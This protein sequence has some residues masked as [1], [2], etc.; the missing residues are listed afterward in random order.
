MKKAK[1]KVLVID[2]SVAQAVGSN[3]PT[4]PLR[5]FLSGVLSICHQVIVS[6]K[7][8]DEWKQ[9]RSKYFTHW[10]TS[11]CSR[12]KIKD[13]NAPEDPDFRNNVESIS[14][15][16]KK[17]AMKKDIHLIEA[18]LA[19]DRVIVSLDDEAKKHFHE[20]L[21]KQKIK[22]IN[23]LKDKNAISLLD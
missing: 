19:A 22:W 1:S 23:P 3:A 7:I 10:R 5:D 9:H 8:K 11:M 14:D 2:A 12:K 21:S 16:K 20:F 13:E 17:E 6:P 4:K 18:A 15:Q